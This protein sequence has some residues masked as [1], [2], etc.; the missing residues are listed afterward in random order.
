[1]KPY[2]PLDVFAQRDVLGHPQSLKRVVRLK[3]RGSPYGWHLSVSRLGPAGG[4]RGPYLVG[5]FT[6]CVP[7]LPSEWRPWHWSVLSQCAKW[8]NLLVKYST[9]FVSQQ[10]DQWPWR[11][12]VVKL[13]T[14]PYAK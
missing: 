11:F 1:M 14:Q 13:R 9:W 2:T 4:Q 6:D 10:G 7:S 3:G 12:S 5:L 8:H